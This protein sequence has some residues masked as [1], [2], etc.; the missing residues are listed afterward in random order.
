[1]SLFG[2][3]DKDR[4]PKNP[5]W[6]EEDTYQGVVEGAKYQ[7]DRNGRNKLIIPYKITD[8]Q[9]RFKG[10][11]V[12][13]RFDYFPELTEDEYDA[14]SADEQR[15][16]DGANAAIRRRL[17][18]DLKIDWD[19]IDDTWEPKELD[20]IEV[21]FGVVNRGDNNEFSNIAWVRRAQ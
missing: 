7:Q 1:M 2:K 9:S 6:V 20:G 11:T 15:E 19:E 10:K 3:L 4:I 17:E 8:E 5:W 13:D 21:E 16:I 18:N 14:M 12:Q